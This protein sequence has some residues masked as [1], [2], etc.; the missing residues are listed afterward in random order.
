MFRL[1]YF[2]AFV[3]GLALVMNI[4]KFQDI[5]P[6]NKRFS[7]EEVAKANKAKQ[8]EIKKLLNPVEKKV[9]TVEVVKE[10]PLVELTTA[11]L[12][13]GHDL[14]KKCVVCHGKR[15]QGK[16]AQKAP[17]IG[18]QFDWYLDE[19]INNMRSGVRVNKVM[20][21]YIAKLSDD[22]VTALSAYITK[23]PKM[24]KK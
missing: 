11:Q 24:G 7:F 3:T 1:I 13:L 17:A 19:Q 22:D 20:N 18:G 12:Q 21:P 4:S 16:A 9:E 10:G 6:Q 15:G 14:Y 23:L 2:L 5:K 8:D